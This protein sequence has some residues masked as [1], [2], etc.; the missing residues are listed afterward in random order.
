M[1]TTRSQAARILLLDSGQAER[2]S[3][4]LAFAD[5][6][7]VFTETNAIDSA[8]ATL[9]ENDIHLFLIACADELP[10]P[11]DL[12]RRARFES[13]GTEILVVMP[14]AGPETLPAAGDR[15]RHRHLAVRRPAAQGHTR[16]AD[17]DGL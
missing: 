14:G 8:L 5:G 16:P 15:R 7:Y 10:R 3:L 4:S 13:P 12:V 6:P 17:R 11:D 9:Q 1:I 2:R